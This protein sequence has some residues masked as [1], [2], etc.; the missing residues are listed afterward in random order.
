MGDL[1]DEKWL[2][3]G[4]RF[5]PTEEELISFYL[6]QKL[7][8]GSQDIDRVIPEVYIYYYNPWDLPKISGERCR[9]D[10]QLQEWFFFIPKHEKEAKGG[11]PNRLT[12]TGYW[13]ATGSP[14]FVYSS[15]ENKVIG[16]KRTM[17]FYQGRARTKSGS[18][19]I[20]KMNE[21]MA[22]HHDQPSLFAPS[23]KG[24]FTVCRVYIK[25]KCLRAFDRRP[26][27]PPIIKGPTI[28]APKVDL[29]LPSSSNTKPQN[30]ARQKRIISSE[31]S[32]ESE[33]QASYDN[34]NYS[35]ATNNNEQESMMNMEINDQHIPIWE[36]DWDC[37]LN[38]NN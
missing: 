2:V 13:K 38:W 34:N 11:R 7:R 15:T 21:Y 6:H 37:L 23:Q 22:V 28:I 36:L 8:G 20:W 32:S 12:D 27:G 16:V 4:F 31:S 25:S 5:Y 14:A 24:D 26:V 29:D 35:Q 33:N 17:V 9:N 18:K 10:P 19:T 30:Q 3:P 1:S